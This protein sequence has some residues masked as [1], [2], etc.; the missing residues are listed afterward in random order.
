MRHLICDA[1][2]RLKA[3]PR[4]EECARSLAHLRRALRRGALRTA[5]SRAIH[6]HGDLRAAAAPRPTGSPPRRTDSPLC[7]APQ[8]NNA[9]TLLRNG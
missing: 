9:Q 6:G 8:M 4:T 2:R 7:S 5:C 1:G 3:R